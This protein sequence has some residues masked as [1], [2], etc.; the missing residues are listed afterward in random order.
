MATRQ[1]YP[2]S[3]RT[4]RRLRRNVRATGRKGVI[5]IADTPAHS[6][7][8]LLG[9]VI[10]VIGLALA[11]TAFL[12]RLS[13]ADRGIFLVL[14]GVFVAV[15]IGVACWR[16]CLTWDAP[17]GR[18]CWERGLRFLGCRA[19]DGRVA[20]VAG[21][22]FYQAGVPD[23]IHRMEEPEPVWAISLVFQDP[24]R[25]PLALRPL[26]VSQD[27]VDVA[28]YRAFAEEVARALGIPL[29]PDARP[30]PVP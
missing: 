27:M 21:L 16:D 4:L 20:E 14:A 19:Y 30:A 22:S 28:E 8:W 10:P 13:A 1:Q 23:G 9:G 29:L 5:R 15:G 6:Y 12:N 26:E 7:G 11:A 25:A 17:A 18:W 3:E 24:D 2:K